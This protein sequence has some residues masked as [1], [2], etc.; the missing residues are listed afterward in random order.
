MFE[1]DSDYPAKAGYEY[2]VS[3]FMITVVDENAETNGFQFM[4]G[5][6]DYFGFDPNERVVV[7][8]ELRDSEISGFKTA[9]KMLNYFDEDYE[10]YVKY[11]LIQS[12]LVGDTWYVVFEYAFL[13]PAGYDGIVVY[14]S[15]ASNW[16]SASNRVLADNFDS[17]T[18]FFRLRIQTN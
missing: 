9:D 5:H 13:V 18:L 6:L 4:T 1:S 10:Y 17:E 12:E 7:N 2:I 3:R 15:N 14:I 11:T 16:S 8:D